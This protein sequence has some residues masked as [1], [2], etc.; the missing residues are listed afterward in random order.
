M[1]REIFTREVRDLQD[2]VLAL[3]SMVDKAIDRSV[4]AL[5]TRHVMTARQVIEDDDL[6]DEKR[7]QIEQHALLLIATQ[8][9]VAVDLRTIAAAMTIAAELERMGDYA[10]GI[11]KISIDLA[12]EPPFTPLTMLPRMADKARDMLDRSL[13][14]YIARDVE[15][16]KRIWGEDDQIDDMYDHVYHELL[17]FMLA[18]SANISRATRLLWV[19]HN[20]ERIADRV[21]NICEST[22]FMVLGNASE[23]KVTAQTS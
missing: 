16:S 20:L 12:A 22:T 8:Q 9:P 18:D 5:T 11:A 15:A 23:V 6:L 10:E 3:G 13:D 4:E 19:C 7:E 14:A 2:E 21:T 17:A 1:P